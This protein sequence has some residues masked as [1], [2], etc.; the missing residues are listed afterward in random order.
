MP[1]TTAIAAVTI[2][3]TLRLLAVRYKWGMTQFIYTKDW[4]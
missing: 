1:I 2:G 3:L 4:V